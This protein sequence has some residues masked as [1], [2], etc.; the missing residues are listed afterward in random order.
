M[1]TE[2]E[3]KFFVST[4]FSR[5]IRDK[6][7]DLKVLQQR[8]RDLG[9][10]YYDTPDYL[11]RRHDIGLRVRRYDDV[12]VQ[13]L[14]T[15]GRVVAGLHQ[16]PEYNAEL[17]SPVPDLSLIPADAWPE[18]LD[19]E[20]LSANL[21]PLF[22]TDFERQQ[23]LLAMPDSSQVELA[24]DSGEVTTEEGGYDPICEVELEL[25]SGQT[26]ALFV[27]ARELAENG[28]LRLG[29][30]SKAARGYRL[31]TGYEGEPVKPLTMVKV[32]GQM[33]VEQS[34]VKALEHALDHWHYHEQVYVERPEQE[35]IFE[36]C[37]AVSLIR[38]ALVLYGGLI[39]RRA[40]AL[41][42]QELQW[43]E[44]ELDWV[45]EGRAIERLLDDKGHFLRKLNAQKPLMAKLSDRY[46][47]LPERAEVLE[48]LHS[49]RY[50][51]L[52]LDLS[53]WILTRGWQ[54][55][56]DDKAR[57]KLGEPIRQFANRSLAQS[58][59]ELLSVFAEG[60]ELDRFAYLDQQPRLTRNL[61]SGCCVAALFETEERETFRLPW[62][63]LLQGIE[64]FQLLEPVRK[65]ADDEDL[66]EEDRA[67]IE[68]W[69]GRKEE[70]L[71]H[72]MMQSRQIGL[73]LDPYWDI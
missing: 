61:M 24:F 71:L 48:L 2:I 19:I 42:R 8:Q 29:N 12:F 49:S 23:W 4:D 54:P 57:E 20:A 56:L 31:A 66:E 25:K 1:E 22:S 53:R 58:W 46:D 63:D 60:N 37:N 32:N 39:P 44:G 9:N 33:T 28:G 5:Q 72:A 35:A 47:E 14:K 3:L 40:S 68:K 11:L 45:Y 55:F 70:S 15:A 69:L 64:D 27:L 26:D 51:N 16:R 13:T 6:I 30:L 41:L 62:L 36:M 43:L 21:N 73:Q 18:G 67:Q 52:L 17:D 10:I 59:D 7:A 50:C 65:L 34:F 38:Q